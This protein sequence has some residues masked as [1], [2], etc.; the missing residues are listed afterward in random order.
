MSL[1]QLAYFWGEDAFGIEHAAE[2]F[3]AEL[4]LEAGQPLDT[5]RTTAG[6]DESAEATAETGGSAAR[7]QRILA[8]IEERTGTGTLFGAG[9]VVIVRQPGPLVRESAAREQVL[10][11]IDQIA[12][13]NAIAFVDLIASGGKG[14]AQAGVLRDAIAARKGK[15]EEFPAPSRERME[16]WITTRAKELDATLGPGA[17]HLLA[18]RDRR[19]RPRGRC[20]PSPPDRARQRRAGEAGSLSAGLS[21]YDNRC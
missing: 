7:R 19:I 2:K 20:G 6:G 15:V 17:A 11:A 9:T 8:Q 12:P 21:N 10:R 5:W 18:E 4:A 1:P 16:G 13:G 14:P 3:A